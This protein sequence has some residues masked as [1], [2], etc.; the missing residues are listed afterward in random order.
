MNGSNMF[1]DGS[2]DE[3]DRYNGKSTPN[4]SPLKIML[5]GNNTTASWLIEGNVDD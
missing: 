3:T 4:W 2:H 1:K 5:T